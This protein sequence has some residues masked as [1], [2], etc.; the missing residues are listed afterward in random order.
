MVSTS[1]RTLPT[2]KKMAMVQKNDKKGIVL[3][4]VHSRQAENEVDEHARASKRRF[5]VQ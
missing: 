1:L 3:S 4:A 2:L 5:I